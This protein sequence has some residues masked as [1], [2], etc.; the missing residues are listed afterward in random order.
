MHNQNKK[1]EKR[2]EGSEAEAETETEEEEKKKRNGLSFSPSL[3][4]TPHNCHLLFF[5]PARRFQPPP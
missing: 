4:L 5:P 3:F 1:E 2:K